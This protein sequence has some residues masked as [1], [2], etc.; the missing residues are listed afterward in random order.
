MNKLSSIH[1]GGSNPVRIMG[2]LNL[3]P[4]SFHKKSI[5]TTKND[6]IEAVHSMEYEGADFIDI[7]GMSTAPYIQS[8]ISAKIEAK[9]ITNAIK[10]VQQV[11][12][13][14]ISVDT[15]TSYVA[16]QA[17]DLGVD[18]INDISGLKYD[19]NMINVISNYEVFV[20]LT[21]FSK[22]IIA[23][24]YLTQTTKL[25]KQS[26]DLARSIN[27][28]KEKIILDPGIG[29][30]RNSGVGKLFTRIDSCWLS[31]DL[32]IIRNL[33]YIKLNHPMLIS[34]SN[35]S[36]I[37]KLLHKTKSEDRLFGSIAAE[38]ISVYNGADIVRTHNVLETKD[39]IMIAEK[40]IK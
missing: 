8:N 24:N 18:I 37:G 30:F 32:S 22:T 11:S 10:I 29:F 2:I 19:V 34:V 25:L 26:L 33:K 9:R 17:L 38:A 40:L 35:K 4:E 31:R 13:I 1:F 7:G 27:I 3:S 36:F 39:A 28:P 23:G 12:N 16:K 14:P 20:V 15:C 5:K 6:I 21:A